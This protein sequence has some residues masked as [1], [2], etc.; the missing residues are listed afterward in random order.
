MSKENIKD[1][2]LKL[3][4]KQLEEV[5]G[6]TTFHNTNG[7]YNIP[8]DS[9]SLCIEKNEAYD[10]NWLG[11]YKGKGD[12]KQY[13]SP[14]GSYQKD[15]KLIKVSCLPF[16][17]KSEYF[18]RLSNM[19]IFE[20][21]EPSINITTRVVENSNVEKTIA[22]KFWG[23]NYSYKTTYTYKFIVNISCGHI[24]F[25]LSEQEGLDLLTLTKAA[26]DKSL[27][28]KQSYDDKVLDDKLN[29]RLDIPVKKKKKGKKN[30]GNE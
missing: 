24:N 26:Y 9:I 21:G 14:S 20:D 25:D 29:L 4:Y 11:W 22:K 13:W 15:D 6:S 8:F 19:I 23:K 16:S 7:F 2:I 1:K 5:D 12:N 3:V 18:D 27:S 28:L 10:Y 30:K 17:K